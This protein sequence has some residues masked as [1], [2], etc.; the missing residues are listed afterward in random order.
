MHKPRDGQGQ[1]AS[2]EE[3]PNG[4]VQ[5]FNRG[6]NRDPPGRLRFYCRLC[7]QE[8]DVT[9]LTRQG[10]LPKLD[11]LRIT[12]SRGNL[13]LRIELRDTLHH[14][15]LLRFRQLREHGERQHLSRGAFRFWQLAG[16]VA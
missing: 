12:M 9:I 8:N 14:G 13:R 16:A 2:D 6:E 1:N 15:F 3:S 5:E 10:D 7:L 4:G 11:Y